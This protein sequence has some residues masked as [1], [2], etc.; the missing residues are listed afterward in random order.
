MVTADFIFIAAAIGFGILGLFM[1]FGRLLKWL[2]GGL[3]GVLISI[4]VCY[5]IF[6]FVLN[7]G[8][9]QTLLARFKESLA[10]SDSGIVRFLATI[11]IEVIVLAVVLFALVQIARKIIVVLLERVLESDNVVMKAINKT[12]GVV[13]AF[14]IFIGL[15]LIAGQIFYATNGETG[16]LYESLK[17]SFFHLDELYLANPMTSIIK[18]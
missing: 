3:R 7:L 2:T 16:E 18:L 11:R 12:F 13:L 8:F 5:L 4:V 14:A 1:G 6:G 10:A 17:G 9:V 15:A